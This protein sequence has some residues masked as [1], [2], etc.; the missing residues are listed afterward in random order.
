MNSSRSITHLKIFV[1]FAC[2]L[3]CKHCVHGGFPST[4]TPEYDFR[5]LT[6]LR[7]FLQALRNHNPNVK[8]YLSGGEPLMSPRFFQVAHLIQEEEMTYKTI[9]NGLLLAKRCDNL[10]EAPPHSLWVTFNGVEDRHNQTVGLHNGYDKLSKSVMEALP[11]LRAANIKVG[12]VLMINSLTYDHISKDIETVGALGF[13]EIVIQHLSFIP[14]QLLKLH[15]EVFEETF[16]TPS[17][18]CFGEGADGS[19]IDPSMLHR[20]L[21]KIRKKHYPFK[22]IVFPP[23]HGS[24]EL[25]D[26]YGLLPKRWLSRRCQRAVNELWLLPD[27][28]VTVCFAY[29]IG[30]IDQPYEE[31]VA[32]TRFMKWKRQFSK[33]TEPFP[34]CVRCHRLYMHN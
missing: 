5:F 34:G 31:I 30:R 29:E 17:G 22:C 26:Y 4:S 15:N 23:L 10:L 12:A 24:D 28:R 19:K 11:R 32:S 20:E 27:G 14:D 6:K 2:N 21:D 8:V 18:F 9:T 16:G 13:E 25:D 7:R 3:K 33:L 1:S